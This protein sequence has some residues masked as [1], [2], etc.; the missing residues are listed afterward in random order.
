MPRDE[1]QRNADW[2][3]LLIPTERGNPKALLANAIIALREAPE[4]NGLLWFDAF[5]QRPMLRGRPP[6]ALDAV[7]QEWTGTHDALAANWMQL[8]GIYVS[9][10]VAGRAVEVVAQDR[11]YHPVLDYL[12]RCRWDGEYRLDKWAV[13]FLGAED[14]SYARA[15]ASRWMMS[16]VARVMDPGCKADCALILEGPQGLLKSTAIRTLAH[17]WFTDEVAEFGSKDAAL[18]VAGVWILELA[19]LD[20]I[21]RADVSRIKAFMSRTTDRFR[22]PYERRVIERPRQ[23]IFAGTVNHNQYLRDE[24][25]GR[26]FWPISCTKIDIDG[27]ADARDQL[28]AEARD[29][30]L[31]GEPLWLDNTELNSAA[32]REQRGRYQEDPWECPI[33]EW[34]G[35]RPTVGVSEVLLQLFA[36]TAREQTQRDAN[37]VA[38][39]L[40]ALGWTRRQVG[41]GS[42]RGSWL[43][44][45]P[46]ET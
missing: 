15:T 8:A 9:P 26:R 13:D 16:G 24:T 33:R 39:C 29:R 45:R 38:G 41:S 35:S 14:S 25:G 42:E 27:L 6:W 20:G 28:W 18:Q 44:H 46:E 34:L 7:D 3:N 32:T 5:H 1:V 21:S 10:D 2:R 31:A 19:E 37:R 22:P 30:Y 11:R 36:F 4:W 43:Y 17:P 12:E 23:C 40:K